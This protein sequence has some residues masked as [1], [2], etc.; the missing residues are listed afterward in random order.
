MLLPHCLGAPSERERSHNL[1]V[2]IQHSPI[3]RGVSHKHVPPGLWPRTRRLLVCFS[4]PP[5]RPALPQLRPR[6]AP[7]RRAHDQRGESREGAN[8]PAFCLG[9]LEDHL[10]LPAIDCDDREPGPPRSRLG[11]VWPLHK[12]GASI[13]V[14]AQAPMLIEIYGTLLKPFG[15]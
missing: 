13:D 6:D 14:R 3:Q 8:F 11:P 1:A 12:P 10:L 15:C 9:A 5:A 2:P 4:R 7:A